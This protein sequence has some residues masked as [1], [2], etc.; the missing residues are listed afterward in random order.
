MAYKATKTKAS[1]FEQDFAESVDHVI[2]SHSY[3]PVGETKEIINKTATRMLSELGYDSWLKIQANK[4][5]IADTSDRLGY[6]AYKAK[7]NG[8]P[9][10]DDPQIENLQRYMRQAEAR[11]ALAKIVYQALDQ[12]F[13]AI[14]GR[15]PELQDWVTVQE[16]RKEYRRRTA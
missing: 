5:I 2:K 7:Q 11:M 4:K 14:H 16:Q 10:D 1:S 8:T 6:E 13:I 3:I 12:S 9:N 15:V